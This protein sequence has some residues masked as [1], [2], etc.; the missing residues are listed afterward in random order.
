[1]L[2]ATA[3]SQQTSVKASI[4]TT[5]NQIGAQ[6]NLTL[7]TTVDTVARV[8]FP[9]GTTFGPMEVIRDYRIDTVRKNNRYELIKKYG[10]AQFDSGRYTIPP[11]KVS[12]NKQPFMT[13]PI[14]VVVE[15]VVVD[16]LKQKMYD[17]KPIVE[18]PSDAL[19]PIIKYGL[20]LVL[21]IGV[22]VLLYWL[23]RRSQ[24]KKAEQMEFKTPIERATSLL[25]TLEKKELWQRGEIKSYYTELTDI[26]RNY[27]EEAIHIPAMESTTGE[28]IAALREASANKNMAVSPEILA[29]LEKVLKQADLVKFAQAKPL[30]FEI[31]DHRE[32]IV[33]TI[34]TLDKSIPQMTD[35]E[36]RQREIARLKML[37]RQR[38]NRILISV[39]AVLLLFMLT[40][41]YFIATKG[42]DFLKDNL[43]GHPTKDLVEGE[44]I[45]SEYGNPSVTVETPKVLQRVINP[46]QQSVIVDT[47]RFTYGSMI[48]QFSIVLITSAFPE[49]REIPNLIEVLNSATAAQFEKEFGARN[50]IVK[51][52]EYTTAQ[53]TEGVRTFGS[54]QLQD[55]TRKQMIPV[56]Y[57]VLTFVQENGLEQ[58]LFI[59]KEDDAYAKTIIDRVAAS[60]ELTK[61]EL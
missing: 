53:G 39:G 51:T 54:M 47:Q 56:N 52:E 7:R 43:I 6:F 22:G 10:L 14:V 57:E 27:I 18:A 3:V 32:K 49:P 50:V 11:L 26:A 48:N 25:Q 45:R 4:D 20:I 44:W 24:K 8:V 59:F 23:I 61:T 33:K 40:I 15:N 5:K 12:I 58:L 46:E 30:D 9:S 35:D 28:L 16:T 36:V 2:S 38:R 21:I 60:F 37:Q 42:F 55:P 31:A 41:G 29:S 34:I 13:E 17:I 19:S 1:M